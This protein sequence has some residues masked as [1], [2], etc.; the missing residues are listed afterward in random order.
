MKET[1]NEMLAV[2]NVLKS[3]EIEYNANNISKILRITSMGALKILKRLEKEG[4]LVSRKI[5]KASVYKINFGNKYSCDY[6]EFLLKREAEEAPSYIKRWI[7][8]LRKI[9]EADI[10]VIFGSVL[11]IWEK[12]KDIDALFVIKQKYFN[13]LKRS[14]EKLNS[15]NEKKIHPIYQTLNDFKKN[16]NKRDKIMLDVVKGIVIFGEKKIVSLLTSL[17]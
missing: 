12:A 4:I 17:K 3:P 15:I 2:L 9:K 8:E 16:I 1:K 7:Y 10:I 6:T 5:G 14:I 13:A 11:K